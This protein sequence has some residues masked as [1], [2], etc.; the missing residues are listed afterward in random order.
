MA[1]PLIYIVGPNA[2]YIHINSPTLQNITDSILPTDTQALE[3]AL[4]ALGQVSH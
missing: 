1:A 2:N 4:K 3:K